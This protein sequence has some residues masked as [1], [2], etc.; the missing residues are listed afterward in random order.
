[1]ARTWETNKGKG[2]GVT[3]GKEPFQHVEGAGG[4]GF[5]IIM[6]D[7]GVLSFKALVSAIV[8]WS[9]D[10]AP[11]DPDEVGGFNETAGPKI[12]TVNQGAGKPL[13]KIEKG[14]VT[15]LEISQDGSFD[16]KAA[17]FFRVPRLTAVEASA[18]TAANGMFIYVTDTDA[19]FTA[20]GFWGYDEGVWTKK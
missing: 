3:A 8:R 16:L 13:I 19:T 10:P 12:F 4:D 6:S 20:A 14:G 11:A 9:L 18:L 15:I 5:D 7:G 17:D 2:T 1:M